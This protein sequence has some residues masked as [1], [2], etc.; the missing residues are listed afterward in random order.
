VG[1]LD[2]FFQVGRTAAGGMEFLVFSPT[3][4]AIMDD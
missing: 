4:V 1:S 3:P 2:I